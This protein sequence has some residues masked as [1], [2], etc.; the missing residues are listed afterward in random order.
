MRNLRLPFFIFLA[1]VLTLYSCSK[2]DYLYPGSQIQGS[3]PDWF[4]KLKT[5]ELT[6]FTIYTAGGVSAKGKSVDVNRRKVNDTD[7][8]PPL[9]AM[10][11]PG[12]FNVIGAGYD[13]STDAGYGLYKQSAEAETFLISPEWA[14][15]IYLGA[16]LQGSSIELSRFDPKLVLGIGSH[17]KPITVSTNLPVDPAF[18][19]K[20][21]NMRPIADIAFTRAAL[22]NYDNN[23]PGK[24]GQSQQVYAAADT[25]QYYEELQ[26]IYG[27]SKQ[28]NLI[29][30]GTGGTT[31]KG[32]HKIQRTSAV[33]VK[34][35]IT[36]FTLDMD[37]P[38]GS[39]GTFNQLIDPTGLDTANAFGGKD[40]Y[41]VSNIAYGRM[42]VMV[43]ESNESSEELNTAVQK[44]INILGGLIGVGTGLTEREKSIL[45]S[46]DK[47][48]ALMGVN[49][50]LVAKTVAGGLDGMIEVITKSATYSK[51]SPGIPIFFSLRHMKNS[52]SVKNPFDINWP[53]LIPYAK[54]E[55]LTPAS[56]I[57]YVSSDGMQPGPGGYGLHTDY[58]YDVAVV[59]YSAKECR[60]EQKIKP[61]NFIN[62][63]VGR[64]N[65]DTGVPNQDLGL[66]KTVINQNNT[67]E[68]TFLFNSHTGHVTTFPQDQ[69]ED[70]FGQYYYLMPAP[71][72]FIR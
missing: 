2:K 48:V 59:C 43:L 21:Y 8:H 24:I 33:V 35:Y 57:Y 5:P 71:G 13:Q 51:D 12:S 23:N 4:K 58:Y 47:K 11:P 54:I 72:Y 55:Y 18:V 62:F 56:G 46:A 67:R 65:Y 44:Q 30:I 28:T 15:Q 19:A 41:Y 66:F 64:G 40:P 34:F 63:S 22:T 14:N 3:D 37:L 70:S 52:S 17:L 50:D 25:F 20:T 10:L 32:Q 27:Y 7:P 61:L 36:N 29:F 38:V 49:G 68:L 69:G 39:E 31:V 26:S 9:V 53:F 6:P 1:F 42:G 60:P 45:N 16:I